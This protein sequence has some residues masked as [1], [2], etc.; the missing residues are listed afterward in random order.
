MYISEWNCFQPIGCLFSGSFV[1]QSNNFYALQ[2]ALL[3]TNAQVENKQINGI[4]IKL[5]QRT[6]NGSKSI[7][8]L[9]CIFL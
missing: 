3:A 4:A 5:N 9:Y 2:N 6:Q 8:N 1:S 7:E